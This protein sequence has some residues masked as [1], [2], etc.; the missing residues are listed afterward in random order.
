MA[1]KKIER[2]S[3][4]SIE[5]FYRDYI[6]PRRPV[7][8]TDL[9]KHHPIGNV[10]SLESAR[11]EFRKI[12][13]QVT[14]EYSRLSGST[15]NGSPGVMRFGD[16][17]DF[18]E[19][20]P[21]TPIMCTEY[22]TPARVSAM[23]RLPDVCRADN[24]DVRLPELLNIPRRWGDYDLMSNMFL[25]NRGN[26]AHLHYDGDQRQVLLY[27][28]FGRK[29]VILFQPSS[30]RRLDVINAFS[31]GFS[32]IYLEKKSESE[33][34]EFIDYADGYDGIIEPGEAVYMPM[35]IWHYLEY[36]DTGMSINFRFGRNVYGRFLSVDNFHRDYYVQNV[37]IKMSN[38][39]IVQER[40]SKA[41]DLIKSGLLHPS[42]SRREKIRD[43]RVL[44]KNLCCEISPE[45]E[46][47]LH[48]PP[49]LEEKEISRIEAE[50]SRG[51]VYAVGAAS[52]MLAGGSISSSQHFAITNKTQQ[53]CYP[54]G[55]LEKLC[56][57]TFGKSGIN[58][59]T[60]VE[61]GLL[62]RSLSSPG[63]AWG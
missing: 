21:S 22:T 57:N 60:R 37:A 45:A 9:F 3:M 5:S 63:A 25:G 23:Y 20:H 58:A 61:A 7:I 13:L 15:L 14:P 53:L 54:S 50:I 46:P 62:L 49:G 34:Q 16:Y 42:Q 32:N 59:L 10:T 55:V 41:I 8:I 28:V 31:Q 39:K 27:Q 29:R 11:Q 6:L 33:K 1:L 52:S 26:Y 36:L 35:L 19:S 47:E 56:Y 2:I 51:Q 4:P 40:Y 17:L 12:P 38:H 48:C 43:M 44:F 18:I 24:D 30:G